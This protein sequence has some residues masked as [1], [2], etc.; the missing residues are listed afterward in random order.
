M[1]RETGQAG[2]PL[3]WGPRAA[4]GATL[5]LVA[6]PW[7]PFLQAQ[8]D[9]RLVEIVRVAQEGL[10]DSARTMASQLYHDT[11]PTDTLYPQVLYTLGIV[12]RTVDDMRRYYQQIAV[13]YA[14]SSWADDALLRLAMLDYAAANLA[15]SARNLERIRSDY[16]ASPLLPTA[17]YWAAR[18]YF[19]LR[20]P[21][22]ACHWVTDG[23][24]QVGDNV[25]LQNQLGYYG[26]R[27]A[28]LAQ[29]PAEST[30]ADTAQRPATGP[31]GGRPGFAVQVAAVK[32]QSAADKV[33][34]ALKAV[35]FESHTLGA[36]GLIKV[37]VGHYPDRASAQAAAAKVKAKLGGA[38]YVVE[39][40]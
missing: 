4:I 36:A 26:S 10:S 40:S 35:G 25:E 11:P 37:R 39:E 30:R 32:T 28:A 1:T 19:D 29:Q 21:T 24:A 17:A 14:T 13:E 18:A 5:L 38:P 3:G 6:F 31:P 9:S 2:K 7:V 12:A 8:E 33:A 16:P 15:S 34:A 20:R 23:L 22:D 27:C